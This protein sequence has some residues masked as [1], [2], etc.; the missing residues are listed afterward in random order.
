MLTAGG[1]YYGDP[2]ERAHPLNKGLVGWY[3]NL[4]WYNSG[5]RLIDIAGRNHGTLTGGPTW[6]PGRNGFGALN[7]DGSDDYVS[8]P[9]SDSL[10]PTTGLHFS[11]WVRPTAFSGSKAFL[12]AGQG[13]PS[14]TD[15]YAWLPNAANVEFSTFTPGGLQD[16]LNW[17]HTGVSANEWRHW[18]FDWDGVTKRI[19]LD[20]VVVAF[21]GWTGPL[22]AGTDGVQIGAFN[23]GSVF[24]GQIADLRIG[25]AG[26]G[27]TGCATLYDQAR[28]SSPD[29]LRRV[30]PW[31][32]GVATA[33]APAPA[34][35]DL[36]T[37][38]ARPQP[39]QM[40]C[41]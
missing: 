6:V 39:T 36:T 38:A 15:W 12:F 8:I 29:L 41:F 25:N 4:P 31:S 20:G 33:A 9:R 34:W 3:A 40:V 18:C 26:L 7:F 17:A 1:I 19:V 21:V 10:K 28:R 2:V 35:F 23:G 14:T 32:V 22:R 16:A 5:P 13:Y 37:P 24:G 27:A 11:G 30:R